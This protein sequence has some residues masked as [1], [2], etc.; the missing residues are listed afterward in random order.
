MNNPYLDKRKA[1]AGEFF[2]NDSRMKNRSRKAYK[3]IQIWKAA[4]GGDELDKQYQL[5]V[6]NLIRF[7][8]FESISSTEILVSENYFDGS[9]NN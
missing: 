8:F 5:Q 2:M 6:E 7:S 3:K 1:I 4:S 9:L